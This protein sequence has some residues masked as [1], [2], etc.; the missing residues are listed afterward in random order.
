MIV[1]AFALSIQVVNAQ[2]E[3]VTNALIIQLLDEGFSDDEIIGFS[4]SLKLK[5]MHLKENQIH[6][7]ISG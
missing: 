1:C 4:I 2:E 6:G 7:I 5:W 3:V